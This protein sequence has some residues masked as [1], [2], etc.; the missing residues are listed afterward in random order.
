MTFRALIFCLVAALSAPAVADERLTAEQFSEYATGYTLYYE[1]EDGE[2]FG[3]EAFDDQGYVTW[4]DP[5]GHCIQGGWRPYNDDLCFLYD[6]EVECWG[7]YQGEAGRYVQPVDDHEPKLR[8]VRR[9]RTPLSCFG[10]QFD[11]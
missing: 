10:E 8:V 2:E 11:L 6:G 9:D 5:N 4:R 7:F 3:S 1:T